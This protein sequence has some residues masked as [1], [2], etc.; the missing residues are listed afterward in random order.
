MSSHGLAKHHLTKGNKKTNLKKIANYVLYLN[1]IYDFFCRAGRAGRMGPGHCYRLYSSAVF[2]DTFQQFSIPEIQQKPIDD[3]YLQLKCMG[4]DNVQNFPFPS[5]PD[6]L[7][8]KAAEMRLTALGALKD[9]K[10]TALGKA[11]SR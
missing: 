10:A 9:N 1:F 7:Q 6:L 2:N 11:I 5:V 3:L 8:M 4:I